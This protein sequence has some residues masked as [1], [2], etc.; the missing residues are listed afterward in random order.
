VGLPLKRFCCPLSI[1]L[2]DGRETPSND[3]SIIALLEEKAILKGWETAGSG[4]GRADP[5]VLKK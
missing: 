4:R 3:S 1:I 2:V 5:E